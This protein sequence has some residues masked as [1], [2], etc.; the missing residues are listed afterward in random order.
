MKFGTNSNLIMQN[1]NV[2]FF[3]FLLEILY[4]QVWSKKSKLFKR[5]YSSLGKFGSNNQAC[6]FKLKFGAK[7]NLI[8][9][10]SMVMFTFT[11]FDWRY[12]F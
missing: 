10:N 11:V 3:C 4:G 5:K 6:L 9:Q 8:T 7:T 2:Y 1:C 12:H